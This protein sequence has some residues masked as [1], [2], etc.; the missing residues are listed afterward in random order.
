MR[1]FLKAVL[2]TLLLAVLTGTAWSQ[3]VDTR[4]TSAAAP[5]TPPA[6]VGAFGTA[7]D[8]PPYDCASSLAVSATLHAIKEGRGLRRPDLLHDLF[9]ILAHGQR[10]DLSDCLRHVD[11]QADQQPRF[12]P[13]RL[14][15]LGVGVGRRLSGGPTGG[16]DRMSQRYLSQQWNLW[17]RHTQQVRGHRI[18]LRPGQRL[19]P[20][21]R[22]RSA[23]HRRQRLQ[24]RQLRSATRHLQQR[25]RRGLSAGEP[26]RREFVHR[27]LRPG[28]LRQPD[29]RL[30]RRRPRPGLQ[31]RR[32]LRELSERPVRAL[33]G[34][35]GLQLRKLQ[36]SL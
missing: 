8:I 5:G 15:L 19:R 30:L 17:E 18:Q 25:H 29:R 32:G 36:T 3:D 34:E 9:R 12:L 2:P 6:I 13:D 11:G 22:Y 10:H 27:D 14:L 4:A 16:R 20:L 23:V 26:R 21:L 28:R 31:Q 24:S 7:W 1:C 33:R 35:R